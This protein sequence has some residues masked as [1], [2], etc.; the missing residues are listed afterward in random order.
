MTDEQRA[1][2]IADPLAW[3]A[4]IDAT[5]LSPNTRGCIRFWRTVA[6]RGLPVWSRNGTPDCSEIAFD[7]GGGIGL[8]LSTTADSPFIQYEF[9]QLTTAE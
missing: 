5:G 6:A 2:I 3:Q 4:E 1:P 7:L 9:C 8:L